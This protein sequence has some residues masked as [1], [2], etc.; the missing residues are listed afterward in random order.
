MRRF[1]IALALLAVATRVGSADPTPDNALSPP[2]MTPSMTPLPAV[3]DQKDPGT[4]VLLSLAG[5]L[6]PVVI[7]GAAIKGSSGSQDNGG[8]ALLAAGT[9]LFLPSAGHWYAGRFFTPG[10]ITRGAGITVVA[11]SIGLLIASE[12]NSGENL[13]WA[14]AITTA[15]GVVIDIAT[16]GH[17]AERYNDSHRTRMKPVA[18]KFHGGG[19]GWRGWDP[20]WGDP[21][22]NDTYQTVDKFE[23]NAEIIMHHGP[24][25]EGER[26]AF[27]AHEVMTNL[28]PKIVRPS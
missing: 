7:V 23:A 22:W 2:G 26:R 3:E 24:K 5:S 16:A 15:A 10:M 18:M 27:D 12:G 25:P 21:F 20:F 14:G 4:A 19:Y 17:E 9:V 28:G 1:V 11:L 8:I 13:F 6:A